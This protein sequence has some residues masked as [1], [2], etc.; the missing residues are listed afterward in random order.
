LRI[1]D[2]GFISKIINCTSQGFTVRWNLP[3][4]EPLTNLNINFAPLRLSGEN[5]NPKSQIRNPKFSQGFPL[6]KN[7][8]L[9]G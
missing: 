5:P 8:D 9:S 7:Q 1:A 4:S 3:G 6:E 2:F